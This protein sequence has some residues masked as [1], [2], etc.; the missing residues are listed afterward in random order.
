MSPYEKVY[1]Q[2]LLFLLL[3]AWCLIDVLY[4]RQG[5]EMQCRDY[6]LAITLS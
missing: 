2:M 1:D 4:P 5:N 6:G 3:N